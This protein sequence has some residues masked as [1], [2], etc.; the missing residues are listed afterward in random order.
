[1]IRKQMP[2][3]LILPRGYYQSGFVVVIITLLDLIN[4][5][6]KTRHLSTYSSSCRND[7]KSIFHYEYSF[8]V[9]FSR[10]PH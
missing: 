6:S 5:D 3:K 10:S 2:H 1:M 4:Q 9:F 7:I 8:V